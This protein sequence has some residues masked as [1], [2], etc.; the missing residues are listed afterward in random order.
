MC[1]LR[2]ILLHLD[3]S[4]RSAAR[5]SLACDVAAR[6]RAWID[7]L[8]A[9][10]PSML[11]QPFALAL[12]AGG[13]LPALQQLDEQRRAGAKALF[14]A[15]KAGS[16]SMLAWRE[17]TRHPLLPG[18]ARHALCADLLVLG[19]HDADD[20]NTVGLPG[21]FVPSLIVA[22]GR[23]A[24]VV[25]YVGTFATVGRRPLIAW[26]ATPEAARA[27]SAALPL[28]DDA[29]R[30]HITAADPASGADGAGLDELERYLQL[31]GV[32]AAI[33]RHG[34]VAPEAPGEGLLSLAADVDADLLVMGCYGHSRARELVLGGA[35]RT[36][37]QSM[38]LPVLMA[39]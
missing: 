6:H 25:P 11:E 24:L 5:L 31:H 23:P 30:V 12:G 29:Q 8:Y 28:L 14:D 13:A 37:L 19:Q 15:A 3:A 26:K 17:L 2:S 7:A 18:V 33:S 39:H 35:T 36:I 16:A 21:D 22:S 27:V 9:S 34:P 38:T 20:Q 10:T 4:P 32:T 1:A